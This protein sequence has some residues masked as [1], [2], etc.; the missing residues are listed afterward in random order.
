ME[1]GPRLPV[2]STWRPSR[3]WVC[4]SVLR[5]SGGISLGTSFQKSHHHRAWLLSGRRNVVTR[6][7][8]GWKEKMKNICLPVSCVI[9]AAP[10][11]NVPNVRKHWRQ[12]S[13]TYL[14]KY[15]AQRRLIRCV[16]LSVFVRSPLR[17]CLSRLILMWIYYEFMLILWWV[18][19]DFKM[20]RC[21]FYDDFML[22]LMVNLCWF[23]IIAFIMSLCWFYDEF[24]LIPGWIYVDFMMSLCWF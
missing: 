20:R 18:C 16:C 21:W 8:S 23:M 9:G 19:V 12:H 7:S 22:I 3:A 1:L 5:Q 2:W 6:R 15:W 10:K 4:A 17:V 24:M 14:L 13:H 11:H